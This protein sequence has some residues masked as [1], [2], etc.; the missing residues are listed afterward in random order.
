MFSVRASHFYKLTREE[1]VVCAGIKNVLGTIFAARGG[2]N[3]PYLRI[4]VER[5]PSVRAAEQAPLTL[6]Q[7]LTQCLTF[8]SVALGEAVHSPS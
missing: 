7:R 3:R 4:S 6:N 1:V 2:P 5:L 8:D